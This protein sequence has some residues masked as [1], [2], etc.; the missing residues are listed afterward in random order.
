MAEGGFV[1]NFDDDNAGCLVAA[2]APMGHLRTP[3][4][5]HPLEASSVNQ[6]L[7]DYAAT[8]HGVP[9]ESVCLDATEDIATKNA[10]HFLKHV[11]GVRVPGLQQS[12]AHAMMEGAAGVPRFTGSAAVSPGETG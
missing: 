12:G 1:F 3:V 5:L 8:V 6:M 2:P 10:T 9:L 4:M 7:I 11:V